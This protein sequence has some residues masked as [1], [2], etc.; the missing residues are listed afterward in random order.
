MRGPLA[1]NKGNGIMAVSVRLRRAGGRKKPFFR[2]VAADERRATSGKF[3]E[4]L[5]WYDPKKNGDNFSLKLDR[6]AYWTER[7]AHVSET[8]RSL[9]RH[10]KETGGAAAGA[11][12]PGNGTASV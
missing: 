10:A 2:V 3:I 7:G 11:A 4:D 12:T 6:I 1:V 9:I 5:G 8:V